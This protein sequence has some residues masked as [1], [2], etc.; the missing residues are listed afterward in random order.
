MRKIAIFSND[1][2]V[3]GIQKSLVNLLLNL[4]YS[5]YKVDLYLLKDNKFFENKL[6]QKV[7]IYYLKRYSKIT[8]F[9]PFKIL[10]L[11]YKY[12]GQKEKYDVAI[13]YDGYQP[14]TALNCLKCNATKKIMWIHSDWKKRYK[15]NKKFK[16]LYFFTKS[17]NKKFDKYI[18]VSK[19]VIKPF[20]EINKLDNIDY[21]IIP[22]LIDVKEITEKSKEQC[23]IKINPDIYNLCS[24]GSLVE[25]KGYDKLL[26]YLK[27]VLEKRKDFHFYLIGDGPQYN[28]LKN[29]TKK[30]GIEKQVTFLGYQK[31]PY[32]YMALM[33]GFALTS[34]YEGQGMVL[35]EAKVLGLEIFMSKNLEKY[36]DYIKGY[37]GDDI[38][39][40]LIK[41][42]KK[43][44][45]FDKLEKYNKNILKKIEDL[46]NS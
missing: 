3:G 17:K 41:A 34:K 1:L 38:I 36:N 28:I 32:K 20:V 21:M 37:N 42:K 26:N 15:F 43:E 46:L 24:V 23:D 19:G 9:I 39:S 18:G 22:N 30:L 16:I 14:M 11:I 35:L 2:S 25:S 6:P 45:K 33:D 12:H 7:N 27:K 40:A 31:N 8:T 4:D 5:K 44:K 10:Y 13:D 29:E